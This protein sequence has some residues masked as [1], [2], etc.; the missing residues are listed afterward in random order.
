MDKLQEMLMLQ[1]ALQQR[2]GYNFSDMPNEKR[3]EL[4]KEFSI[5]VNQEMNEML[6][7]LPFF[8]PWKDYSGMTLEEI[9]AAFDKARKEFIDLWHFILNIALLLNMFSDDIYREYVDKNT[10]NHRR[11]DEGYTH[12]KIYR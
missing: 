11:Q 8:K 7:E 9:E 5:H 3:V 4:I 6:Y 10:E 1:N 12:N 2:L